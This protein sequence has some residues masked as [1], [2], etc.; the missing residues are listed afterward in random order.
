MTPRQ[1]YDRHWITGA[2]GL[3]ALCFA[4][5]AE[6]GMWGFPVTFGLGALFFTTCTVMSAA[7]PP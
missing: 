1:F 3:A 4:A 2:M 5:A 7:A 6:S